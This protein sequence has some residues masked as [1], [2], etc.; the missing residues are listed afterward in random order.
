VLVQPGEPEYYALFAEAG[1]CQQDVFG[2]SVIGHDYINNLMN[3]SCLIEG[4]VHIVNWD[5]LGQLAGQKLGLD[6]KILVNKVSSGS[7]INH[8]LGRQ[9]FHG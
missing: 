8:G 2:V 6:D 1:D 7:G 5:W 9:F 3:T 4:S